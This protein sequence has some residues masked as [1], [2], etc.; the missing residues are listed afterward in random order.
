MGVAFASRLLP[1]SACECLRLTDPGICPPRVS[2]M[3]GEQITCVLPQFPG[4]KK[5]PVARW[6]SAQ[7]SLWPLQ[8]ESQRPLLGIQELKGVLQGLS[9]LVLCLQGQKGQ[10]QREETVTLFVSCLRNACRPNSSKGT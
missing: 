4:S 5:L 8:R 10:A 3:P 1:S 2:P 6:P 9:L 7:G